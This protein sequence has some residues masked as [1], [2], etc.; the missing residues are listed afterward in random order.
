MK[1]PKSHILTAKRKRRY[2]ILC[3]AA[4]LGFFLPILNSKLFNDIYWMC[5]N[6]ACIY[7]L[8]TVGEK[9]WIEWMKGHEKKAIKGGNEKKKRL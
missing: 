1:A 8:C 4:G 7:V 2:D 9:E 5:H 3:P 6:N